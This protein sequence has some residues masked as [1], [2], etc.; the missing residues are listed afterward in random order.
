VHGGHA[1]T[2]LKTDCDR[3]ITRLDQRIAQDKVARAKNQRSRLHGVLLTLLSMVVLLGLVFLCLCQ[4][5]RACVDSSGE[6]S[7]LR[8]VQRIQLHLYSNWNL[9]DG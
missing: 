6:A 3:I 4:V 9:Q 7:V 2:A 8:D 1:C 5:L